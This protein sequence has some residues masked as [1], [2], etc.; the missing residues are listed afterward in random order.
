MRAFCRCVLAISMA[1]AATLLAQPATVIVNGTTVVGARPPV[2]QS[3]EY[4][5]PLAPVARYLAATVRF[6]PD[7]SVHLR[8][9]DGA[10][11]DYDGRTGDIRSG[12]VFIGHVKNYAAIQW[13]G[14]PE[15]LL[16]PVSAIVSLLSVQVREDQ[17]RSTLSIDA[18]AGVSTQ[19]NGPRFS[20]ADLDYTYGLITNARTVGQ[21]AN[22]HGRAIAGST[23]LSGLLVINKVPGRGFLTVNQVALRLDLQKH[24]A[25]V[26][27]DQA[28]YA[29]VEAM[30]NSIR[31]VSFERRLGEFTVSAYGGLAV[32]SVSATFGSGSVASYD[33]VISGFTLRRRRAVSDLSFGG[34]LFRNSKREGITTGAAF[35]HRSARNQVTLQGTGG[36]FSGLSSRTFLTSATITPGQEIGNLGGVPVSQGIVDQ[37]GQQVVLVNSSRLI[38]VRGPAIGFSASDT[39]TPV[40]GVTVSG[41]WDYYSRNFLTA[42]EATQFGAESRRALSASVR[43]F[44]LLTLTAGATNRS[45][46]LGDDRQARGYNY[47][48]NLATPGRSSFQFGFFRSLQFDPVSPLGRFVFEQYALTFPTTKSFSG[49]ALYSETLFGKD[50]VRNVNAF[51]AVDKGYLG[52]FGLNLS[53]QVGNYQRLGADWRRS[54]GDKDAFIRF[55]LDAVR[56]QPGFGS[57]RVTLLPLVGLK[58]RLPRNQALQV[59]YRRELNSHALLIEINGPLGRRRELVRDAQ[60]SARVM[61]FASLTGRVYLDSNYNNR[62]DGRDEKGISGMKIWLD[63]EAVIETDGNGS[64]RF[65]GI[66]PGTH[67][68]RADLSGVPAGFVFADQ[69]ERS[70]AVFPYRPNRQDVAIIKTAQIRGSVTVFDYSDDP[71][72]PVRR[73]FPDA[74]LVTSSERDTFSEIDGL[75]LFGDLPPQRYVISIDP[76]TIPSGYVAKPSTITVQP[77]PG[78]AGTADFELMIPPRPVLQVP[79]MDQHLELPAAQAVNNKNQL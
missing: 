56:N 17:E 65:D 29:G 58:V 8:L 54:L 9:A 32:G 62:L 26:F 49:S 3:G 41:R 78:E 5:I 37:N 39:V 12:I 24:R 36:W 21:Y 70:L 53:A 6:G 27:G 11:I 51:A 67:R 15:Q 25:F 35:S 19:Q 79:A 75:F 31:G 44:R 7:R 30:L 13:S 59:S 66:T 2:Q 23:V 74:R 71:D 63:D 60:G 43:P 42:R 4:F 16:F 14:D 64:Y 47:G 72:N 73:P 52:Q 61:V 28:V 45:Y 18:L 38:P 40:S 76:S 20:L 57:P 50:L 77:R 46:L 10:E 33:T 69:G 1:G 34:N 22:L 48:A 55:G 68:I